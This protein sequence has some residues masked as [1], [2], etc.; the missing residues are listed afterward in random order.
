MAQPSG[1]G[2]LVRY[3]DLHL[4]EPGLDSAR[5]PSRAVITEYSI[6]CLGFRNGKRE[7]DMIDDR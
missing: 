1:L 7:K 3:L 6:V 2:Q 5:P 4:T